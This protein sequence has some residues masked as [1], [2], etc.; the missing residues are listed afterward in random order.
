MF[1]FSEIKVDSVK[2]KT[3]YSSAAPAEV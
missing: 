2:L 1:F 3:F